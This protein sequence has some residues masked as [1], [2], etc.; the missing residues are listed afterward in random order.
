MESDF[1]IEKVVEA[2]IKIRDTNEA[3]EEKSRMVVGGSKA[4]YRTSQ[5][6]QAL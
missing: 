4:Q 2:Y 5:A 6:R 1:S 3:M